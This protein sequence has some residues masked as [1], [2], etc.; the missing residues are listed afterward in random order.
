MGDVVK[1]VNNVVKEVDK[2][3]NNVVRETSKGLT[4]AGQ[5][6][7]NIGNVVGGDAGKVINAVTNP[8]GATIQAGGDLIKGDL[9]G[10]VAR[11]TGAFLAAGTAPVSASSSIREVA[12]HDTVNT[13]F[14]G[15]TN[16]IV[17]VNDASRRMIHSGEIKA[18]DWSAMGR[19]GAR[20]GAILAGG[21][22]AI[23]AGP[24]VSGAL[25]TGTGAAVAVGGKAAGTV[26]TAVV[27]REINRQLNGDKSSP[28][29][30]PTAAPV[31]KASMGM[32][33]LVLIGG[34]GALLL[35]ALKRK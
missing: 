24:A 21:A 3:V 1:V 34:L 15:M 13:F 12:K 2:G 10:A 19:L 7:S 33:P 14:G 6:T 29:P 18:Q 23:K 25:S 9:K 32:M 30:T 5:V 27:G 20:T 22:I 4:L 35:I 28:S 16:D 11:Q 17:E 26:A 31:A 8:F